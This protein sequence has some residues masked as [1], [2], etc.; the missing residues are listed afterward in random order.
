[1]NACFFDEILSKPEWQQARQPL[2]K[3]C[4]VSSIWRNNRPCWRRQG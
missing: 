2:D 3:T 4:L 1:M